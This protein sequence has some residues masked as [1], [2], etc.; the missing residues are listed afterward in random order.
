MALVCVWKCMWLFHS[1]LKRSIYRVSLC[2]LPSSSCLS[3]PSVWD[4]TAVGNRTLKQVSRFRSAWSTRAVLC[5]SSTPVTNLPFTWCVNKIKAWL[6]S[7]RKVRVWWHIPIIPELG[8]LGQREASMGPI[9]REEKRR[10]V[11]L[12]VSLLSSNFHFCIR[13]AIV[14]Y[15]LNLKFLI[16]FNTAKTVKIF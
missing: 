16:G 13:K 8:R 14:Y 7:T 4:L 11:Y 6:K 2:R 5:F 9:V 15:C 1:S 3:P 10:T 12:W